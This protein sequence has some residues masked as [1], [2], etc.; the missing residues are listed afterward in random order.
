MSNKEPPNPLEEIQKQLKE[1]FKDSNVK[2]SAHEF[3]EDD[4]FRDEPEEVITD[5]K[6]STDEEKSAEALENIRNFQ[7]KPKEI[8]DHLN[9]F[10][11]RQDDAKKVLSVAICD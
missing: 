3:P 5:S 9:R 10:V 1:L 4:P 11:I 7:L 8:R 2:I 6:A